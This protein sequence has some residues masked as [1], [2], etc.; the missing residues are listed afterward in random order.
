M[1]T[2]QIRALPRD[3]TV[4]LLPGGILEE[5]GPYLPSY[6]DGYQNESLTGQLAKAIEKRPGWHVLI[7][8]VIPLGQ[9]AANEIGDKHVFPGSYDIRSSTL[10]AVFMDLADDLG[11]QRFR[12]I[13]IVHLH[14]SPIH[15]EALDQAGDYFHDTY[16]GELVSLIGVVGMF[17]DT[18]REL[19]TPRQAQEE[20]FSVHAGMDETSILLHL[21]PDLVR[22]WKDAPPQVGTTMPGLV[23]LAKQAEW[24]GYFGA[25]SNASA[26]FGK[27]VWKAYSAKILERALQILD[28]KDLRQ[29]PR[30]ADEQRK[31]IPPAS[32]QATLDAEDAAERKQLDWLK[33]RNLR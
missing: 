9:G 13:F 10:R 2:E 25:P 1:N 3:K 12:R 20:A 11:Q 14:G 21:R 32:W 4:V 28:G 33:K 26:A 16:G 5:H 27:K 15:N 24:P 31:T 6:T 22:P 19:M 17:G 8:P 7:F 30:Y 23:Q 18:A 29:F